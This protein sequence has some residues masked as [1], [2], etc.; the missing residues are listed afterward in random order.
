MPMRAAITGILAVASV[1]LALTREPSDTL[2]TIPQADEWRSA[3]M[4]A[5]AS[6]SGDGRFVALASYA[7]L[8]PADTD[9]LAD[10]YVLDRAS[11]QIT[12]E[13]LSA[14]DRP[15]RGDNTH[16]RLSGD[17]RYLVFQTVVVSAE[18]P[19]TDTE[20]VLRDRRDDRATL[21]RA[22]GPRTRPV[23]NGAPAMSEDGRFVVFASS[24]TD[25]VEGPDANGTGEDVYLFEIATRVV[26]R[27]SVD[28]HGVQ[29][30]AGASF[31]PSVSG[32]GR[33]VS[34][35]STA[36]FDGGSSS[37]GPPRKNA[38]RPLPQVYVRDLALGVTTR[39]SAGAAG[40]TLDGASYDSAISRDGRAVAF[41]SSAA[42]L[43]AGDRNRLPDVFV[44]D[45]DRQTTALVS[46]GASGGTANGAS[47]GPALSA[48]GRFVAFQSE[49]S[50]LIC[51]RRCP[52]ALDDLNLLYDV[53]LF[54]RET[55]RTTQMSGGRTPWAESSEAPQ[56]DAA[57]LTIAFTSR[58]PIDERD[59]SNDFD[60]F[61]RVLKEPPMRQTK[62]GRP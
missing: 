14:D 46:R 43:V 12:I 62:K 36:D 2:I 19:Q 53:F 30:A 22:D 21:V 24:S 11:G 9:T 1:L 20:I 55:R 5:S 6:V 16:P 28:T 29:P 4:P 10:I 51:A 34:F 54:E 17:G 52:E 61:I 35:T 40:V 44:R 48:D 42:N 41:V 45:V 23:F 15:L 49:A 59:V 56:L 7:R 13:S 57:G 8:V 60:L 3:S 25:V 33:F 32:E 31:A 47:R 50:D 37:G 58:H 18:L 38:S 27:V 26:R 39:V